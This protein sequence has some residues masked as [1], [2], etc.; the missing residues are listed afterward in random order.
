[1]L[2]KSKQ[3]AE[4]FKDLPLFDADILNNFISECFEDTSL[5]ID[6]LQLPIDISVTFQG[7]IAKE[8]AIAQKI[9]ELKNKIDYEKA[10]FKKHMANLSVDDVQNFKQMIIDLKAH[11]KKKRV[12]ANGLVSA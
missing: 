1:M 11:F 8:L 2:I 12:E 9:V 4:I 6:D 10:Q 7:S 5:N 3:E